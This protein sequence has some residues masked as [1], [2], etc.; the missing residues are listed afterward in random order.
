MNQEAFQLRVG[1]LRRAELDQ[2]HLVEL[3]LADQAAGVLAVGTGL[4]P[5]AGGVGRVIKR[6]GLLLQD[7]VL[8]DVGQGHL[9]RRDQEIVPLLQLEEILL[10]FGKLAGAGHRLPVDDERRQNFTVAVFGGVEVQH[11]VDQ[12]P[13]QPGT[14]A[15]VKREARSGDLGGAFQVEDVQ[16]RA[17]VPMRLGLEGEPRRFPPGFH[18]GVFGAVPADRDRAVGQVGDAHQDPAERFLGLGERFFQLLDA[19]R[20]GAHFRHEVLGRLSGFFQTGDLIRDDIATV[21]QS[22]DIEQ[23]LAMLLVDGLEGAEVHVRPSGAEG[24]F[25]RR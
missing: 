23:R 18:H 20:H 19:R 22:F 14:G 17:D 24:G 7:L 11:E 10:E 21:A 12:G 9:G 25:H 3:V 16:R 15:Q 4:R 8:M 6:Q 2:L 13:L 1:G 5:E